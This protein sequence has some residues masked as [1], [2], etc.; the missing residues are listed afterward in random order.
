MA[1]P[2]LRRTLPLFVLSSAHALMR[3]P[4]R[5]GCAMR[6]SVCTRVRVKAVAP[7]EALAPMAPSVVAARPVEEMLDAAVEALRPAFE[8]VDRK[9]EAHMRRFLKAFRSKNV[10]P[11]HFAGVDGYGHGDLGREALDEIYAEL[12]G[13]EAAM[14]R[15]QM[16]SGT[17]AIACAL[18]GVLRPGDEM[19][20]VSGAQRGIRGARRSKAAPLLFHRQLL[21]RR[22]LTAPRPSPCRQALRHT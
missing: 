22:V 8:E 2:L 16:F 5:P 1:F 21:K 20:A 9:T 14:V 13:A 12:F 18:F 6:A 17:H 4:V 3:I 10:G 15:I 7:S 19:L 11:H